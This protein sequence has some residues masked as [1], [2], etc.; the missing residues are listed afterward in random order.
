MHER[1]HTYTYTC[2]C[3]ISDYVTRGV[4]SQCKAPTPGTDL[5][6][7]INAKKPR[8]FSGRASMI[9]LD[10]GDE[11]ENGREKGG[12]GGGTRRQEAAEGNV[13]TSNWHV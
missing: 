11:G 3:S 13:T 9:I 4:T 8:W 2:I 6:D 7:A 10:T 5:E 12:R 1:T